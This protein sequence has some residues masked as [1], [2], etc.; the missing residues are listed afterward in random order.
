MLLNIVIGCGLVVAT[1]VVHAGAM[2]ATLWWLRAAQARRQGL[3]SAVHKVVHVAGT[4]VLM[5]LAS[6]V[7][8]SLW[9]ATYLGVGALK[10][11]EEALYFSM[12]T[13]TTLGFGDVTL[14]GRW[15]LLSSLEAAN[16]II[17]FGWTTA[18]IVAVV[19]RVYVRHQARTIDDG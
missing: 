12:V 9:A 6:A 19:Q 8:S 15:R 11:I 14:E 7:E 10:N 5:F 2:I 18:L 4:A 16:G 3:V 17:M 1:T 13:Y